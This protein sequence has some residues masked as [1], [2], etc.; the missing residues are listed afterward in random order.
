MYTFLGLCLGSTRQERTRQEHAVRR[1]ALQGASRLG[2]QARL[3]PGG[4]RLGSR[5]RK[6]G[7]NL[8]DGVASD[9]FVEV[10]ERLFISVCLSIYLSIYLCMYLSIHLYIYLYLYPYLSIYLSMY[11]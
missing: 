1:D 11:I 6:R 9:G 4:S 8:V 5:K 7:T 10:A 3:G 2:F